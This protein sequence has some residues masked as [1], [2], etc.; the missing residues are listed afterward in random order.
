[1]LP[2]A[3]QRIALPL[4]HVPG[5][6]T[7][8]S[9]CTPHQTSLEYYH[10]HDSEARY[11]NATYYHSRTVRES[12]AAPRHAGL[13]CTESWVGWVSRSVRVA[14]CAGASDFT[15]SCESLV[16]RLVQG[17]SKRA[18]L[19]GADRTGQACSMKLDALVQD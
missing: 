16:G 6:P 5:T 10:A 2:Q 1:M 11:R 12:T 17:S 14:T 19:P 18:V 3:H 9:H 13:C 4:L 8:N 7:N 15:F